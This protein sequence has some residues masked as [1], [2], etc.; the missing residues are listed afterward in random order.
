[1][2]VGLPSIPGVDNAAIF[3]PFVQFEYRIRKCLYQFVS[4]GFNQDTYFRATYVN[5]SKK[6]SKEVSLIQYFYCNLFRVR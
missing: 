4:T 5:E 1:M 2:E 6:M 3:F